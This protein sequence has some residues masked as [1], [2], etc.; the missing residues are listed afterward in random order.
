MKPYA[1]ILILLIF[2]T[3]SS[4]NS[5]DDSNSTTISGKWNMTQISGGLIGIDNTFNKGEITW[6]FD[7]VTQGLMIVNNSTND[8]TVFDSGNYTYT[9]QNEEG[10][11]SILIN[12]INLGVIDISLSAIKIDQR[13][14]DGVLIVLER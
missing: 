12:N 13:A 11:D 2:T 5:D 4:C 3:F 6:T 10:Y 7:E 14:S 9:I 8:Y 1:S